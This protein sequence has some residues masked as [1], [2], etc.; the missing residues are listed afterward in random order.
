MIKER[1]DEI[2]GDGGFTESPEAKAEATEAVAQLF[3]SGR[4]E[5]RAPRRMSWPTRSP[6]HGD[7]NFGA[8][9][10]G[11]ILTRSELAEAAGL[12]D[13]GLAELEAY[14]FLKPSVTTADRSL[15]DEDALAIAR[16]GAGVPRNTAS[17]RATSACTARS[18]SAKRRSS[19][20][21][22][23][24]TGANAIPKRVRARSRRS[25]SWPGSV[26]SCARHCLQQNVRRSFGS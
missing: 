21:C 15:F 11:A 13:D 14:G 22:S 4:S 18:S 5:G 23:C 17:N 1:L 6:T 25:V 16:V 19:S 2:D 8:E 24:R 9:Y 26:V 7:E 20:R 3:A 12:D 10:G